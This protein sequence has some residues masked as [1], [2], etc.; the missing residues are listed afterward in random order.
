MK[1]FLGLN[2]VKNTNHYLSLCGSYS[3]YDLRADWAIVKNL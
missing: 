1:S 2:N 3:I